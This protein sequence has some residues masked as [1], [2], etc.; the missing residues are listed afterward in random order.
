VDQPERHSRRHIVEGRW[1]REA[2]GS[3]HR[4][5]GGVALYDMGVNWRLDT[6]AVVVADAAPGGAAR[7]TATAAASNGRGARRES[8]RSTAA[9]RRRKSRGT[10]TLAGKTPKRSARRKSQARGQKSPP[11]A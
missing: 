10:G 2:L 9:A 7:G 1:T 4:N 5:G 3:A 11:G 8:S 6:T